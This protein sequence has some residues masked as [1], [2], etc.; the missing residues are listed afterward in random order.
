MMESG[1]ATG[2]NTEYTEGVSLSALFLTALQWPDPL[3]KILLFI[4]T[5]TLHVW[6]FISESVMGLLSTNSPKHLNV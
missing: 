2:D 4:F 6:L 3:E 1:T 5:F